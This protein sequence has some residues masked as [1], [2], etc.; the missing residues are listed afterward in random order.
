MAKCS[1]RQVLFLIFNFLFLCLG[2]G[3]VGFVTWTLATIPNANEFISGTHV[4]TL[5]SFCLGI[6]ILVIGGIGCA[7][8]FCKGLCILKTYV[9]FML[10]LL[11]LELGLIFF[12]YAEKSQIPSVI[13]E[14]WDGLNTDTQYK[15]QSELE[16]CGIENYTEYGTD[17]ESYPS[18]CFVV[19]DV[20]GIIEKTVDNLFTAD[21]LTQMQNW[22]N[23]HVPIWVSVLVA[24]AVIE[25]LSGITSCIFLQRIHKK[26]KVEPDDDEDGT[27]VDT[28]M[29]VM[30][31]G[32]SNDGNSEDTSNQGNEERDN[33]NGLIIVTP[34]P[35]QYIKDNTTIDYL[36]ENDLETLSTKSNVDEKEQTT[37]VGNSH[38]SI[39][40]P[41][42]IVVSSASKQE[43]A[44]K[45]TKES[46]TDTDV[47]V[48]NH[49]QMAPED[50]KDTRKE[51]NGEDSVSIESTSDQPVVIV[52][53]VTNGETCAIKKSDAI[54]EDKYKS[55]EQDKVEESE[56]LNEGDEKI[57]NSSTQDQ[58]MIAVIAGSK[59]DS[60]KETEG[61]GL[62]END[63]VDVVTQPSPSDE[64]KHESLTD[65]TLEMNTSASVAEM[66][67]ENETTELPLSDDI[68][69]PDG[70][71]QN[72]SLEENNDRNT[73]D[74]DSIRSSPDPSL[75]LLAS[76]KKLDANEKE[77]KDTVADIEMDAEVLTQMTPKDDEQGSGSIQCESDP[78]SMS[79]IPKDEMI[80]ERKS[81]A[82]EAVN[83]DVI[84]N[85]KELDASLIVMASM[86]QSETST[87][88]ELK[89][90]TE[91]SD[92]VSTHMNTD[93][94]T[95]NGEEDISNEISHDGVGD[96]HSSINGPPL[97]VVC[98]ASEN[99]AAVKVTNDSVTGTDE[100]ITNHTQMAQEDQKDT[101]KEENDED[102]VSIE[103]TSDQ[104]VVIVASVTNGETC[105]IKKSDAIVDDKS[106]SS[107]QDKVE[108]SEYLNERDEKIDN[109]S[110]Q[111]QVM[112][113]A[114]A[115]SKTD[116]SKET[117]GNGLVE[118]D[119]VDVVTQ[120]SPSDEGK[121]ESL[122]D[123][124][125]EMNTSASV[126]EMSTENETTELPLSDDIITPDGN[127]QNTS[128][129]ENND[130]NTVDTDSIRSS[131][132]P[133]LLLLASV[134]KLDANEKETKDTV[135]DIE[136]DAELLTQMTP[137]DDEQ[138]NVSIQCE[139]DPSLMSVIPK[140]EMITE[141]K[142]DAE[143]AVNEDISSNH[144]ELDASLIVMASMCQS[145][146]STVQEL[147]DST[148]K[149]DA[150][151][152]HMNTDNITDNGEEDISNEI[153]HDGVGD[154]HS[155]INGPPL[156]VVC[157]ASENEAAVKVT[158][159]SV[160]GTDEEITNHTQMAQEDQKDTRKEENDEDSVSIESTSD[161]PVVIVASVTN[162]E[163]CA[164]KK[165]DAIV[166]DKSESSEQD[167]V[168]ESEYLNER[169]EKIDN[170]S[171]QNQVMIAAIAGSKT[172]SSKETEGNGL[173]ENDQV[174]V[175]TQPSPSDE[176]KHESLTDPTLEMNTSASVAEMSTENET[177]ELPFS[178]DIVTPDGKVQHSSLEENNDR[179][180]HDTD[181]IRSSPDP[182]L[183][184]LASVKKLDANEK[185]TKVTVADIEMDA[186]VLTQMTPK[187]DEQGSGSIQCESEPSS[188]SVI[189]KDEM[190]TERKSDAEEAVNEDVI[191][192]Q[193]EL[194]ASLIVMA[195]MCQSETST[196]QE[197]K[198]S[199]EKSDAVS[200][201]MNTDN[202]TDNSEDDISNEI[203][204]D[205]VGNSHSIINGPPLI[206]A[207]SASENE[208]AVKETNDSVTGTDVEVTN[209]TLM[210]PEDPKDTRKE[211]ND[212][213][214]VSIESTSDR[215]VVIL[216]SV[217]NGET[218]AIKKSDSIV[219]DKS[220]SSEQDNV[221]DSEYLNERDEKIDNTSTQDQ[222]MIAA[223]AGSKTDHSKE[224]EGN[225][226][227][228]VDVVTQ[229]SPPSDGG[230]QESLTD[231]TLEMNTSASVAEMS[232]EKETTE[233]PF[234]DD[235]VTP[236]SNAQNTSLDEKND[237]NTDDTDSIRSSPDP[238]LLLLASVKKLDANEKETKDTVADIEMDA[239]VL[240]QMTPKD[241][242]QGN[243]PIQCESDPSSM[244]VIPKDEMITEQ[245]A[246][247]EETMSAE[248]SEIN[249]MIKDDK[250]ATGEAISSIQ[251]ELDLSLIMMASVCQKETSAAKELNDSTEN[252]DAGSTHM[253]TDG[254][255]DKG[256]DGDD[257]PRDLIYDGKSDEGDI[258]GSSLLEEKTL[259]KK[260]ESKKIGLM[261]N[262]EEEMKLVSDHNDI[263]N[264][265]VEDKITPAMSQ[266]VYVSVHD[267]ETTPREEFGK[268]EDHLKLNGLTGDSSNNEDIEDINTY[269][270]N[271]TN[272][273]FSPSHIVPVEIKD[274]SKDETNDGN[275]FHQDLSDS[276]SELIA[277]ASVELT[278]END[279]F[280][281]CLSLQG[282]KEISTSAASGNEQNT[283]NMENKDMDKDVLVHVDSSDV[284][285]DN[286]EGRTKD[287][288]HTHD[289]IN[290]ILELV[291][292]APR[293]EASGIDVTSG[294]PEID[295]MAST[296]LKS[297]IN[298]S[299]TSDEKL[300]LASPLI[301]P[302]ASFIKR[303]DLAEKEQIN[304][305]TIEQQTNSENIGPDET[306]DIAESAGLG[307]IAEML[308]NDIVI[309][310][311]LP[312]SVSV[313]LTDE[314]G[315]KVENIDNTENKDIDKE[316]LEPVDSS[317]VSGDYR[318][319]TEDKDHNIEGMNSTAELVVSA[320]TDEASRAT[321]APTSS[322]EDI[323]GNIGI[324][325]V[326]S[327]DLTSDINI[328]S[329]RDENLEL[330][331][332]MIIPKAS[333]I[334]SNE[335]SKTEQ[336]SSS[337]TE[338]EDNDKTE[339]TADDNN[340]SYFTVD[341]A[342]DQSVLKTNSENI[343]PEKSGNI[344]EN[345]GLD[346]TSLET[347][348]NGV[349]TYGSKSKIENDI[350]LYTSLHGASLDL[351]T[352]R[353]NDL[354]SDE[355]PDFVETEGFE[356]LQPLS[357]TDVPQH[358][359]DEAA[360][361]KAH[362]KDTY[363]I[364]LEQVI[365]VSEDTA[366]SLTLLPGDSKKGVV[367]SVNVTNDNNNGTTFESAVIDV[368][369][370]EQFKVISES[371]ES[372]KNDQITKENEEIISNDI[373][374][375]ED[376][377]DSFVE[378]A[379]VTSTNEP[380]GKVED[381]G[382]TENED[383]EVL[384]PID[385][386]DVSE[387]DKVGRTDVEDSSHERMN[388]TM[389]LAASASTGKDITDT[390][391]IDLIGSG[392]LKSNMNVAISSDE[393]LE[394]APSLTIPE[395]YLI[396]RN[397]LSEKEQ[398]SSLTTEKGN[399]DDKDDK[400]D[401]N[402]SNN[403]TVDIALDQS[404][405]MTNRESTGP[406]ETGNIT[407]NVGLDKTSLETIQDAEQVDLASEHAAKSLTNLP[408]HSEKDID[409]SVDV[410]SDNNE[411]TIHE[412]D[413]AEVSPGEECKIISDSLENADITKENEEVLS[414][415][416]VFEQSLSDFSVESASVTLTN[417]TSGEVENI[418]NTENEDT[419]KAVP[420][421]FH[422][423]DV[424][425]DNTVDTTENKEN[426]HG[427][428]NPALEIT[429]LATTNEGPI[430]NVAAN[431]PGEDN[432]GT[433][434]IDEMASSD[435]K[436]YMNTAITSDGKLELAP[437]L[438]IPEAYLID[439][440]E[441][442]EKKQISSSTTEK[443]NNDDKDEKTDENSLNNFTVDIAL[444][445]SVQM[446][447]SES[448]GPEET[449][450]IT[451]NV[452]LDKTSLETIQDAD[453]TNGT[454]KEIMKDNILRTSQHCASL[455]L[456][457]VISN[458]FNSTTLQPLPLTDVTQ[459]KNDEAVE[460]NAHSK[461]THD[462]TLKQIDSVPE[463]A[464]KSLTIPPSDSEKDVDESVDMKSDNNEETIHESDIVEVSPGEEC[465]IISDSLENADITKENEEVLSHDLVFNQNLP[466]FSVESASVI[467]TS[468]TSG[469][470]ENIDNT[471]NEDTDKVV[472]DDFHISDV[473]QD[474]KEDTT[475]DK[476]NNH[477][478][479]NPTL[480][481]SALATTNE[482]PRLNV[483]ANSLGEDSTGK[484]VID[485]M[486]SADLKPDMKAAII[487]D[488]KLELAP[489][490]T[491]PEANLIDRN[492]LSGKE[493]ISSST[494][495]RVDY[496]KKDEKTDE[497][498]LNNFT[499]D[500]ALDQSV[501][502]TSNESTGPEETGNITENAGLDKT[503][504]ETIQDGEM[505]D[506][507]QKEI[508][509]DNVLNK[510]LKDDSFEL[511][512]VMSANGISGEKENTE[513]AETEDLEK[514]TRHS[515]SP[516]NASQHINEEAVEDK[517]NNQD[518]DNTT[519]EQVD[520]VPEHAAKS[521]T[522]L[523]GDSEKDIDE[524][525][526]EKSDTIEETIHES[527]VVEVSP[528]EECKIISDSSENVDITKEN[529]EVLSHHLVFNQSLPDF[530][531]ESA[532]VISTS[533]TSGEVG[534]KDN[535]EN[536]D[537]DKEVLDPVES[538]NVSQEKNEGQIE[539][540]DHN[541][542]ITN[543]TLGLA[544]P[545][546][547]DKASGINVDSGTIEI[548]QMVSADLKSD[549]NTVVTSDGKF[550][551]APSLTIPEAYLI[552]GNELSGK[553]QIGSSTTDLVN[554][555]D[556]DEKMDENS[557]NNFTVDTA[558]DQSV[559]M[560]NSESTGPEETGNITENVGLDKTLLET[561]QDVDMTD[562]TK[563]EIVND[564]VLNKSLKDESFELDNVMSANGIS[565]EKENTEFAETEDLEKSYASQHINEEA[566]EDT[567][568][569]QN[570]QI[571]TEEKVDSAP[572]DEA[573][574]LTILQSDSEKDVDE[575]VD[576]ISDNNEETLHESD[577]VDVSTGEE[578]N[579]IS[580]SSENTDIRKEN[581]EVLSHDLVFNQNLPIFSVESASVISTNETS[582]EVENIDNTENKDIDKVVPDDVDI[583]D[584]SQENTVDKIEDKENNHDRVNP[585]LEIS[586]LATTNEGPRLNVAPISPGEDITGTME[587]DEVASADM[588]SDMN[589][590][591]TTEQANNDNKD[592]KTDENISNSFTDDTALDQSV[593]MTNSENT[594]PEETGNIT[595][596]AGLD[597]TLLETIQDA[598]MTDGTKREIVNDNVLNKSLKDESFELDNV[599]SAN[600]ILGEKE[601]TEFAET[602]DFEK[603]YASQH[604]NEEADEDKTNNQDIHNTTKEHVE[605]AAKSLTILPGDSEK[606][607][608]ESVD[609][610]SDNNEETLHESDIVE[611]SNG[612]ECNI[613]SDS[614][615]NT[616]ITK[617]NE[618]VLSHDLVF[619]Q[620]ENENHNPVISTNETSGVVENKDIDNVVPEAVDASYVSQD[621]E[622]NINADK[623]HNHENIN[624]TVEL[625]ASISTDE[626]SGINI[627]PSTSGKDITGTIDT[628]QMASTDLKSGSNFEIA[629]NEP[630]ELTP[631]LMIPDTS[632]IDKKE[633]ERI[634]PSS[635]VLQNYDKKNEKAEVN[636]LYPIKNDIPL[637]R[638]APL[639]SKE[640]TKQ[641]K[642]KD[643]TENA[644]IGKTSMEPKQNGYISGKENTDE[645]EN[646]DLDK[647]A[648]QF[649]NSALDRKMETAEAM[650]QNQDTI[651]SL[652]QDA[653]VS[654]DEAKTIFVVPNDSE[655]NADE[656]DD[657]KN[658]NNIVPTS[659]STEHED[660]TKD[661]NE[662]ISDNI[663]PN[664]RPR[665]PSLESVS[666]ISTDEPFRTEEIIDK[667]EIKDTN[668][669]ALKSVGTE[670]FSQDKKD[671]SKDKDTI[672]DTITN[673]HKG[674]I[675]DVPGII[676]TD[677]CGNISN[678]II[679]NTAMNHSAKERNSYITE[680]VDVIH[681]LQTQT[682][683]IYN[684]DASEKNNDE[685]S[686]TNEIKTD[687]DRVQKPVNPSSEE[688]F[689]ESTDHATTVND[690]P[691]ETEINIQR[692]RDADEQNVPGDSLNYSIKVDSKDVMLDKE[693][694]AK[695]KSQ[696]KS[697]STNNVNDREENSDTEEYKDAL[698]YLPE[699][700]KEEEFTLAPE[701][702][703][704]DVNV[705]LKS[706]RQK[707]AKL[708]PSRDPP[709]IKKRTKISTKDA[710]KRDSVKSSNDREEKGRKEMIKPQ[711][712]S[713]KSKPK[714]R[715]PNAWK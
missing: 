223:I 661:N 246:D 125:L 655:N 504:L 103:S 314:S 247:A 568:Y 280:A 563:R 217:T 309:K 587:I 674:Q 275:I 543:L 682:V 499:V 276:T 527:D 673:D 391:E 545:I 233:L 222:V 434:E 319:R 197:L 341:T 155:S 546:S 108:E 335:V 567:T 299:V 115:G 279:R 65:Q 52:A 550:E 446:T 693:G 191:S 127:A 523:P 556:K 316:V 176:G 599:M 593:Q 326:T 522:I 515:F 520:S 616:N 352:V 421:D 285:Q 173:V 386:S 301:I 493:K 47:E 257:T 38:S 135:A 701:Q 231:P 51:E 63:Q 271:E 243:V 614:L 703:T 322:R 565:G 660:S 597:K 564:N 451:A 381:I 234:S 132:D 686:K 364:T 277:S 594:G 566:A 8:G 344:T 687:K 19:Y 662:V 328:A 221:E 705:N 236:D 92:A 272:E 382:K 369:A 332:Q 552:D 308:S 394:L 595:E 463:D 79:V 619:N 554:N 455:D 366:G 67:T 9:G 534:N 310:Q 45:E 461:D 251:K 178:D 227:V 699:K 291:A 174:D 507:T 513:F 200:P 702:K 62:V 189:P 142:S 186:E 586:A 643:I 248:Q 56:D 658:W 512:N 432:T 378:S 78:S 307:K 420:D 97:V 664:R 342:L 403:F 415:D 304:S 423:S 666:V 281:G 430:L 177:T 542:E 216:A 652:E 337:T 102:S 604:I 59:T 117:E 570:I 529:E 410:K 312:D 376:L 573:K 631:S 647:T 490:L 31:T 560:T 408:N 492:E 375:K 7:A 458:G 480:E 183:L 638:S 618:E 549:M 585:V 536:K 354:I 228:E 122:T 626:I 440:N 633:K 225:D 356:T 101:R 146:T 2:L 13:V 360:E 123:Q 85:Q 540:E 305:F 531:V 94:I 669:D 525:V 205:S 464:A 329:T 398:I 511:D 350:I 600:G 55:S 118:N 426:N 20:T 252:I 296:D 202:I 340:I 188:M 557:S 193:K 462:T 357:L 405:L 402:I 414:H 71:A 645:V 425:Q 111:N 466:N 697:A 472:P 295:Q 25:C 681:D 33:S 5:T 475:E 131:P 489:S 353:S 624:P 596:N 671:M 327:A 152:T 456:G 77:T 139:S 714:Y 537:M 358:R 429:A 244:S 278:P 260:E 449:G 345:A 433:V 29:A 259:S 226:L 708:S 170:T 615:E 528:G 112:I 120:P 418:D 427:R 100:E 477:D 588:K 171:T 516:T 521:L 239:E 610:K 395:A 650:C 300:E 445:Q 287:E 306:V 577:I 283:K 677:E 592:E 214:S 607:V 74:T 206:V 114:I 64:G 574:S 478:G 488:E 6:V 27:N 165:S 298:I 621:N 467:S 476:E 532:S 80:T 348:Q 417:E 240:T 106:E 374:P 203:S 238:S 368:S 169:D 263:K 636:Q 663:V 384:D 224:T 241:D 182:S 692:L 713:F 640:I 83:E 519:K 690:L 580:D 530:Y 500:T 60:S 130:R 688:D 622:E 220:E 32:A 443:G 670:D 484:I 578:C 460:D 262:N 185:E 469:E 50:Q 709:G 380:Y 438:T 598:D 371:I 361:D 448:T 270:E 256:E 447:N 710:A 302:E 544:V 129:E 162:G 684:D 533:E 437:S 82:E 707:N 124:T 181:S 486:A 551:L 23:D 696:G 400:T 198:D 339:E 609:V 192:N 204:S 444:D 431:I 547:T 245:K 73:V 107:E 258:S 562:G 401:E 156:V 154:S 208:T 656:S 389:E 320:S 104:P 46:V 416:L 377:L 237:R 611:V 37:D 481:I 44:V 288:N 651:P 89:D 187:D 105:A 606:D 26:L 194:D 336:I 646:E 559:L 649:L 470:V 41:S 81:D 133:S 491:I 42:L 195:S 87:V 571:T 351:D 66:S 473:S 584:V 406:E 485:Q 602:E 355:N 144:R 265:I 219:D 474:N 698:E 397:E 53:S 479:G 207:S 373:V 273:T 396:V 582:G 293:D 501:L 121:H 553:E 318:E 450:N 641:E 634:N 321:V 160:T 367:E 413:I 48:T 96:S 196:E 362:N 145:E 494:T 140:D 365:S 471:E 468:E 457:T 409:K 459:H 428:M 422:I 163:T 286:K 49:T 632:S 583:G 230:K 502:M 678:G 150:V 284:S 498:S 668:N 242:E 190:I 407:E 69:T 211:E 261:D 683:M 555:D 612:E 141:Q 323:T 625:V 68:V 419:D 654:V 538:N 349:T 175:V 90:S 317:D 151:S 331:S 289:S 137:K 575:S 483:A 672:H 613:I 424:S 653:A 324:D 379:S 10:T 383:K 591:I 508:I 184:L 268:P 159:D 313:T 315:G 572:E 453:M 630:L 535:T 338:K 561:I 601:N 706:K 311:D 452:G 28:E 61:N 161:Q 70:K 1:S 569:N 333:L 346:K 218:C 126:A 623:D 675:T 22:L 627:T 254:I 637:D 232:T 442:S 487:S 363:N 441:L 212:E 589:T 496:D 72:T 657:M 138:G 581:E 435:M 35:D 43:A 75:L 617:E 689:V 274:E 57:D 454:E 210:T 21:C 303:N 134:K 24:I 158:N 39:N 179:N 249:D 269:T 149:S 390:I 691:V 642:S 482:G 17:V 497:N 180:T 253:N 608:D 393:K 168:D 255:T 518:T 359:R 297:D 282:E 143:E 213:D 84:S 14:S 694:G 76:V 548:D 147:K 119:Q 86:C 628:D 579:I 524:S 334:D 517:T 148:E 116:S 629:T 510:S 136:M 167:K 164:I 439:R 665:G 4:V 12:I 34:A 290:P 388:P 18:S 605:D 235:I 704:V 95:D 712:S 603:S 372:I 659:K 503:L 644:V 264:E 201:H 639:S 294:K 292:L 36:S 399:N 267:D 685:M 40:G 392:D 229:P 514:S 166:D 58:V 110:T 648:L 667:S 215:P 370:G 15:I 526:D 11:F 98:S 91:K 679:D 506:G 711:Q 700:D 387:D 680:D 541:P 505:T 495:E 153:S 465:K 128:L 558:L 172:D 199:T 412:S 620:T 209:H 635:P 576:V 16:C 343:E 676:S 411:D 54:V 113:A 695:S 509:N 590:T 715:N 266:V 250:N 93:N 109:T 385:S 539:N 436:P 99:E 88:Q 30:E 330:L 157:S 3:L 325:Q 347:I 404:V